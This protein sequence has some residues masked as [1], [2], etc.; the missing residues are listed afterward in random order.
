M[1]DDLVKRLRDRGASDTNCLCGNPVCIEAADRIEQ[2][3]T[4]VE[5]LLPPR[6]WELGALVKK[7]SGSNWHGCVVGF[8]S[9]E[10]TPVG[11]CIASAFENNSVQVFPEKA[12]EDWHV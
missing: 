4:L 10:L 11:Y 2:L 6:R 5:S 8:Y 9:T 1:T 12:L 7:K 3:Q